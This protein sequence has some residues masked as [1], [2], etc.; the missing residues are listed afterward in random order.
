MYVRQNINLKLRLG[1]C[2]TSD[3]AILND[4]VDSRDSRLSTLLLVENGR[5]MSGATALLLVLSDWSSSLA[6][7]LWVSFS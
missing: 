1:V 3:M 5:R 7:S 2:R 4:T 6:W